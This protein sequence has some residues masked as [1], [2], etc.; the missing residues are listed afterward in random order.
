MPDCTVLPVLVS[1]MVRVPNHARALEWG[2]RVLSPPADYP[3]GERQYTVE[4][5]GGHR[6]TFSQSIAD[7][8]PEHWGGVSGPGME[9]DG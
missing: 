6:W 2:G 5:F 7:L 8:R 3:Y 1:L 9:R 4:D